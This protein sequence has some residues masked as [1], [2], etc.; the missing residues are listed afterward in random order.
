MAHSVGINPKVFR[1]A[2][3]A[4]HFEWHSRY[5]AWTVDIDSAEHVAMQSVLA[6]LLANRGPK[7]VAPSTGP[8]AVPT[9]ILKPGW[10][11]YIV[12]ETVDEALPGIYEWRIDGVGTYIG[13]YTSIRR[14][15]VE[16]SNNVLK[17]LNGWPY[18]PQ[19]PDSFRR[20]HRELVAAHR[21]G[22]G[23]TLTI[24]ENVEPSLLTKRERELIA[25]R[26]TLNGQTTA[27]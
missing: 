3:R 17:I 11:N 10:Y 8:K 15:K 9:A 25:E 23:I 4:Q 6:A 2:L 19:K 27:H 14:P 1:R 22:R 12:A 7:I 13:K 24:L 20:I 5:S 21:E 26:G 16:Y 18:R